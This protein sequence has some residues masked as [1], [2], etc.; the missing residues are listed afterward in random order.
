MA[1]TNTVES[2]RTAGAKGT[3][4]RPKHGT[5]ENYGDAIRSASH[6]LPVVKK[7]PPVLGV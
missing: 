7:K 6:Q 2:A 1:K 4:K 5:G 3:K